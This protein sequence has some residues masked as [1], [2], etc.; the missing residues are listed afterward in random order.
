MVTKYIEIDGEERGTFF[1]KDAVCS[2]A[3]NSCIK[4]S[5]SDLHT[6]RARQSCT[7]PFITLAICMYLVPD[8]PK[9][10]FRGNSGP[11]TDSS[12]LYYYY[13]TCTTNEQALIY[14]KK[15]IV[16]IIIIIN[17]LFVP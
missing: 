4:S 2:G 8:L 11:G 16:I 14:L 3:G 15:G 6:Q 13:C 12:E 9:T 5:G 17:L 1:F 10:L 7:V